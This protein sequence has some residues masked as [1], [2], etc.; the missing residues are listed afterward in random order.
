MHLNEVVSIVGILEKDPKTNQY[1]LL[2]ATQQME[3]KK[4]K[5]GGITTL[6]KYSPSL[7]TK[8]RIINDEDENDKKL[9]M[10]SMS[11]VKN[12]KTGV[13]F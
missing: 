12:G 3:K 2:P 11:D 5:V 13:Y 8:E 7:K 4:I 10:V 9:I 1:I 6:N